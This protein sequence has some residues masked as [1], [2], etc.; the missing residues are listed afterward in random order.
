MCSASTFSRGMS[1]QVFCREQRD[2]NC[3]NFN[4]SRSFVIETTIFFIIF[5]YTRAPVRKAAHRS[6]FY[7]AVL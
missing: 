3:N 4:I 2:K 1:M 7:P 5:S 6:A